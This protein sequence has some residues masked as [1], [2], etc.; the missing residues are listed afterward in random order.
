MPTRPEYDGLLPEGDPT[1]LASLLRLNVE[2]PNVR[3]P[4]PPIIAGGDPDLD[5]LAAAMLG[6]EEPS[7]RALVNALR[8][9]ESLGELGMAGGEWVRSAAA[10]VLQGARGRLAD[11]GEK[12]RILLKRSLWGQGRTAAEMPDDAMLAQAEAIG[13]PRDT[14]RMLTKAQ[15][16]GLFGSQTQRRIAADEKSKAAQTPEA[17]QAAAMKAESNRLEREAKRAQVDATRQTIA[18]RER[19]N[20]GA[21]LMGTDWTLGPSS[22][23]RSDETMKRGFLDS[24]TAAREMRSQAGR[25][26]EMI[27]KGLG[28]LSSAEDKTR[29][30]SLVARLQLLQKQVDKLGVLSAVDI[31]EFVNPQ[32][33]NPTSF[34]AFLKDKAQLYDAK[35]QIDQYLGSMEE[36]IREQASAYDVQ[37]TE[38]G[39]WAH[40]RG[41]SKAPAGAAPSRRF[42]R[43][44]G[45]LVEVK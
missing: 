34:D 2:R 43:V 8:G 39:A 45:K 29:A 25:L 13:V 10:P 18:S 26:K 37:P 20:E 5:A 7:P 12:R 31:S 4:R 21:T 17:R 9:R 32:L 30:K 42:Q 19:E 40:L 24:A 33:L 38:K 6:D 15:L 22:P 11:E 23:L 28:P 16:Q 1:D 36:K 3:T 27:D 44:N 41:G 35:A 14:A